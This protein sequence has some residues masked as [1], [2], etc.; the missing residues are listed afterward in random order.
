[1]RCATLS[2]FSG[3]WS[4]EAA[5]EVCSGD[6]VERDDTLDLLSHLVDKS[7]VVVEDDGARARR[8]RFLESVRQYG[9][10]R[11]LDPVRRSGSGTAISG[12][13][14]TWRGAPNRSSWAYGRRP[15]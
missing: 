10:D 8:Y 1:M 2:V 3:G 13:S 6:G 11:L 4:L 9:R 15:G 12:S 7:L 14:S 5:E